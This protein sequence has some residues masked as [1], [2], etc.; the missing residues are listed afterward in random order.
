MGS[1][2]GFE[3]AKAKQSRS[4]TNVAT[5]LSSGVPGMTRLITI[6]KGAPLFLIYIKA[7]KCYAE[8]T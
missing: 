1:S 7:A 4:V 8:E 5:R 2:G 6:A 3:A